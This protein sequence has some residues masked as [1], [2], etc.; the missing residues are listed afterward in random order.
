MKSRRG[1]GSS[2]LSVCFA[3][4]LSL[5]FGCAEDLREP[6]GQ[7]PGTD[8]GTAIGSSNASTSSDGGMLQAPPDDGPDMLEFDDPWLDPPSQGG[9]LTFEMIGSP[10]WYPS[11][12]DPDSGQCDAIETDSCCMT[13]HE[14][15]GDN[16]S[17]WDEELIMTLRGPM[18]RKQLV[19]YQPGEGAGWS[20]VASWDSRSPQDRNGLAFSG[21][22]AD[23]FTGV[24]GNVCLT[25]VSTDVVF[26]CGPGSEPYCTEGS[27]RYEGW[28]GSKMFV[29]LASMPDIDS[30][31]YD[32]ATHCTQDASSNWHNAPWI[33]LSHG[34]LVRSGKFGDC[35]C[36]SKNPAEWWL[37]DGCGQF[38]V[39]E[40]VNDNNE[41]QNFEV[42]SSNFFGYGGYV[43]DGP[44]GTRCDLSNLADDV[45]LVDTSDGS[46]A[47][48]GAVASPEDGP[49]AALRRPMQGDRYFVIVMDVQTRAVQLAVIHPDAIPT[50]A[51]PLIPALPTAVDRTSV[52]EMIGLRLPR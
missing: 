28:A 43:G 38:N 13:R 2:S 20:R 41:F 42:F 3:I 35:H 29:M 22:G 37:A 32:D 30:G 9:T 21:D 49:G 46:A 33:G 15:T 50:S 7:E 19:V 4:V 44:C 26:P 27:T 14:V 40:T 11:R 12:R 39:L 51:S 10:G 36:Y 52:D 24:V 31:E 17:P 18:R 8:G 16:L 45:D 25:D 23:A 47:T 1:N 48:A 6:T 34:E 5:T